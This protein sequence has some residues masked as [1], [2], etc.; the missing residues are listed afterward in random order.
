M[1]E[2][3]AERSQAAKSPKHTERPVRTDLILV[4]Y[5]LSS[6]L[7]I[8]VGCLDLISSEF[9]L[10]IQRRD[11]RVPRSGCVLFMGLD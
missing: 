4:V 7:S 11:A 9:M 3:G 5:A 6:T 8:T 10:S 1:W 2:T